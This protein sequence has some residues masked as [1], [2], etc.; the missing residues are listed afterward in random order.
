MGNNVKS[1][2]LDSYRLVV[3]VLRFTESVTSATVRVMGAP[4]GDVY[5]N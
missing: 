4:K 3:K 1:L 2:P 5:S